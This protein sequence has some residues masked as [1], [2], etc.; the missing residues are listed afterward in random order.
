[1]TKHSLHLISGLG[2]ASLERKELCRPLEGIFIPSVSSLPTL[3]SA[4]QL[5]PRELPFKPANQKPPVELRPHQGS[6]L[7][8]GLWGEW[9]GHRND[10][11]FSSKGS[12][13]APTPS[14]P[15]PAC[16]EFH[17]TWD[18]QEKEFWG[19]M[20]PIQH[21]PSWMSGH[22]WGSG[23]TMGRNMGSSVGS[24][25]PLWKIHTLEYSQWEC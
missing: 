19:E 20:S 11:G 4:D 15:Q 1:M 5:V 16:L 25:N 3:D 9:R 6:W 7:P 12:G 13:W 2:E 17:W 23:P 14:P 24:Y 18:P 8:R 22:L 21:L 10:L